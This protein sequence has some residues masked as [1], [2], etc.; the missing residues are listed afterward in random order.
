MKRSISLL[1]AALVATLPA[2][3][4]AQACSS[5]AL[6]ANPLVGMGYRALVRINNTAFD[7]SCYYQNLGGG[8]IGFAPGSPT[9]SVGS[10]Q[11]AVSASITQALFTTGPD[12][13]LNYGVSSNIGRT[14]STPNDFVFAFAAPLTSTLYGD[15]AAQVGVTRGSGSPN[16][17]IVPVGAPST[18][19]LG[20]SIPSYLVAQS[21]FIA[22]HGGGSSANPF[23]TNLG[24]D[25]GA[26]ACTTGT[27]CSYADETSHPNTTL[28]GW[29]TVIS[30]RE[31]RTSAT[32]ANAQVNGQVSLASTVPEPATVTLMASGLV[33]VFGAGY[34]RR[35]KA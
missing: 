15:A 30:Y 32:A 22:V 34:A 18:V 29:G 5:V 16:V 9:V 12:P 26:T 1:A 2:A 33:A 27:A 8:Q 11:N 3:A 7:L 21:T 19:A 17:S 24:V 23:A 20:G 28:S 13:V 10:G 35:R 14:A 6:A 25:V 4:H 31:A